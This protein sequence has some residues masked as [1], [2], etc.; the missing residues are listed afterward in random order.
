[1][2]L[3]LHV[4]DLPP[5]LIALVAFAFGAAWGSFFNV[6]IYRW[7]R[8]LSVVK[9]ASHCPYCRARI[10]GYLNIPILGYVLLR[11]KTACCGKPL[12]PRYPI[13]EALGAVLCVAVTQR[14]V[15]EAGPGAPLLGSALIALCYFAFAGGLLVATFVDL[16]WMEI[17]DEV[18]LP[19]AALGLVTAAY[20]DPPGLAAA[21]LGAGGG[22][23]AVQVLFVWTYEALLGRRGMGEGDSKLMM[24]I[25]AFL[26]WQGAVFALFAGA[27]QGLLVAVYALL[28][29]K[30]LTPARPDAAEGDDGDEQ[31]HDNEHDNEHEHE[32]QHDHDAQGDPPP[33]WMGHLKL[34][35]GPFLALGALEYLFFGP[36]LIELWLK[37]FE[38]GMALFGV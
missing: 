10:P 1:M 29:G 23:L 8:G 11:G 35:F 14:F 25:G 15:L 6:A 20:R 31:E 7:P 36:T 13:V 28:A 17:P 33:K 22:F 19:G 27:L 30:R 18:S 9:P 34:P 4:S 32:Q 24:M 5:V 16:E 2:G 21:A 37:L 12:S 3:D 26:G 38:H